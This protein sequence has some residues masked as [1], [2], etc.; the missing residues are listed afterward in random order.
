MNIR[1]NSEQILTSAQRGA[2]LVQFSMTNSYPGSTFGLRFVLNV[3]Q[4]VQDYMVLERLI[5]NYHRNFGHSI[6]GGS[7]GA[8]KSYSNSLIQ[9]AASSSNGKS[10]VPFKFCL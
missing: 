10:F 2:Q 1:Y 7:S 5:S 9:T 8:N 3:L 6:T 4:V